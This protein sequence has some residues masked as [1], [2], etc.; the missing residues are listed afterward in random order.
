MR[1]LVALCLF[2]LPW[3]GTGASSLW[4]AENA[5]PQ[6]SEPA[7][8]AIRGFISITS[9]PATLAVDAQTVEFLVQRVA[10]QEVGPKWLG[11][12]QI[13]FEAL[14][15]GKPGNVLGM[16]HVGVDHARSTL[17]GA[18]SEGVDEPAATRSLPE[19]L[20]AVRACV[21]EALVDI[22]RPSAEALETQLRTA[23]ARANERQKVAEMYAL[24]LQ[25]LREQALDLGFSPGAVEVQIDAL[26][27]QG[28]TL[29]VE[30]AGYNARRN[31]ILE[32]LAKAR[33]EF[34]AA[35]PQREAMVDE[36]AKLV[37]IRQQEL[38]S[39]K[40]LV[41][42]GI[43]SKAELSKAEATLARARAELA[44]ARHQVSA[45]APN[46]HLE[47]L[48]E[49][50]TNAQIEIASTEARLQVLDDTLERFDSGQVQQVIRQYTELTR[51][52][53]DAR[54]Q[55]QVAESELVKL[56]QAH[57]AA[58]PPRVVLIRF[59]QGN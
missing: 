14:P 33:A 51:R 58:R 40:T 37:E 55:R 20:E 27:E 45:E 24:E 56:E 43:A 59:G 25:S 11:R 16:L 30:L 39:V 35:T 2:C 41:E 12:Y 10:W 44:A 38:A 54:A 9:D 22:S 49:Q 28:L 50:L 6:P 1:H 13:H 32:H 4:A 34:E 8:K 3:I 36:L 17:P 5:S 52:L 53:E 23:H 47:S 19:V 18:A 48:N 46:K 29:R 21:E 31:A 15:G 57:N 42:R 7:A 26:R